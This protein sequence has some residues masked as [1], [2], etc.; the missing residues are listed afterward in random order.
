MSDNYSYQIR[1]TGILVQDDKLLLVKQRVTSARG[2]SL[3][4]GRLEHGETIE[5]AILREMKEET[6]LDVAIEKLLYVC[7]K[8]DST[9]P[10]VHI[11]FLLRQ[12][13]GAIALPTNEFDENPISDV[14]FVP[15][16]DLRE[17]GFSERFISLAKDGFPEA[18]SYQGEK[19]NIGL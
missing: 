8:L 17:Y 18:G 14:K 6:G 2:W 5:I 11:T 3:P 10:I 12:V 1:L 4:G 7:D 9:P 16:S 15:I 13:G 19:G